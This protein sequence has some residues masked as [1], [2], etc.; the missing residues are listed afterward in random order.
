LE[1]TEAR[2]VEGINGASQGL[3]VF[4]SSVS[5]NTTRFVSKVGAR[6]LR[7]PLRVSDPELIVDEDYVMIVPS[8]GAG[9]NDSTVPKQVIK[10]LNNEQNRSHIKGVIGSGNLNYGDK[11]CRAAYIISDKCKVPVLYTYEILGLPE[12]V[13]NVKE[14]LTEFWKQYNPHQTL[15]T[16][17]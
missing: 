8:Y 7:V 10:F 11:Y 3:I 9:R 16:Q 17:N 14:G 1:W 13:E 12:D 2:E 4:F 5:E 6:S 15:S